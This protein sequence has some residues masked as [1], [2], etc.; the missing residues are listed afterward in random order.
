MGT[1]QVSY[2]GDITGSGISISGGNDIVLYNFTPVPEPAS[3]LAVCAA[4]AGLFGLAR[5]ARLRRE[6]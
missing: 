3:V 2:T 4:A 1:F 6:I 5:R